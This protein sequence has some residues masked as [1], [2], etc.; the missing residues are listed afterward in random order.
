MR[1]LVIAFYTPN[2]H[3]SG[4][5]TSYLLNQ[6]VG[7][8]TSTPPRMMDIKNKRTF[9]HVELIFKHN[10]LLFD[11]ENDAMKDTSL[12]SYSL[13]IHNPKERSTLSSRAWSWALEY[14]CCIPLFN[15]TCTNSHDTT[16]NYDSR[17]TG[18]IL[19]NDTEERM[20]EIHDEYLAIKLLIDKPYNSKNTNY[21]FLGI[22]F[23]NEDYDSMFCETVELC[24]LREEFRFNLI[25]QLVNFLPKCFE[26]FTSR[27]VNIPY[28]PNNEEEIMSGGFC[29]EVITCLLQKHL[30]VVLGLD[31][32]R[33]SPNDLWYGLIKEAENNTDDCLV[34]FMT[35]PNT[36][37][38][39]IKTNKQSAGL[40]SKIVRNINSDG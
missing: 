6:L 13:L 28:S 15:Y 39:R 40:I 37:K 4:S 11:Q 18:D 9:S 14:L 16:S 27:W 24:R 31:P 34:Y 12:K 19:H 20:E 7:W 29:S 23:K 10:S 35:N 1:Q 8:Y 21:G 22:S 5:L 26:Y 3:E 32:R 2:Y 33:T 30:G 38:T 17:E 36:N 25:G